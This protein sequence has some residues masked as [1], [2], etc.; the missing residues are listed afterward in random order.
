MFI[1]RAWVGKQ[2]PQRYSRLG[3]KAIWLGDKLVAGIY[4]LVGQ[5]GF[6]REEDISSGFI[7]TLRLRSLRMPDFKESPAARGEPHI[8]R[9]FATTAGAA[10]WQARAEREKNPYLDALRESHSVLLTAG[11]AEVALAFL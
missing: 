5:L 1:A 4:E 3:G 2:G 10:C 7:G 6:S 11:D 9:V 8:L